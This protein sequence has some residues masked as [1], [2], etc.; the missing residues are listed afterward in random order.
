MNKTLPEDEAWMQR[1]I[2]LARLSEGHTRPNPPVGAVVV[3]EG[4]MIGE[5]RHQR[6]GGDHAEV[7]ALKACTESAQGATLY[8]TLEPC[9][10]YGRT[11][12]C[13]ERIIEAG[14]KRVVVGCED[15]FRHH[16]G[17]GYRILEQN[18]IEV[19]SGLLADQASELAA[20]FFKH[21]A[22]GRPYLTLKLGMTMDGCIADRH[23]CSQWIT[24]EQSRAEVQQLR[25]RADVILVGSKTVCADDP[26]LLC[27]LPN[28]DNLMRAVIDSQGVIPASAGILNDSAAAR[29]LIFTS[30]K[31]DD[32]ITAA[33]SCKGARVIRLRAAEDGRLVLADVLRELG[34]M[35][36]MHV[37]C[38]GGGELAGAL[39][40]GRLIDE[41]VLFYAPAILCDALARPGFSSHGETLLKD[42]PRMKIKDIRLFGDDL[43]VR[44]LAENK[45]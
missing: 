9:C 37:V 15:S 44:M 4:R 28:A 22:D 40:A 16:C 3:K 39:H 24:G 2:Q 41:Y 29:T 12:P 36:L 14:I 43:R 5:G 7:A 20:P 19:L 30:S 45:S 13:T 23:A 26:S 11:P 32:S 21:A 17:A 33:W 1:A 42:M 8:V 27:R 38:E 34:A 10:T 31:V 35:D 18:K 6:A 25:R